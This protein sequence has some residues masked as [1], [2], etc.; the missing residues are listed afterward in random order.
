MARLLPSV[1][2]L[3][4]GILRPALPGDVTIGDLIPATMPYPFVLARKAGGAAIHPQ[5]VDSAIVDIQVWA[6]TNRQAENLAE[7]CR[8]ALYEAWRNQTV[9]PNVG[10]IGYYDEQ[11][12]P[13]LI[14]VTD[15][16]YRY[17]ATY[18]LVIRPAA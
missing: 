3:L 8:V 11:S 7:D 16:V 17:Q 14:E 15:N 18:T 9:V 10:H 6:K 13:V 5:F 4:L 2:D 1:N 12:S